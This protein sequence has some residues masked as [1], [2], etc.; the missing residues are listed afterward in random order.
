MTYRK[1]TELKDVDKCDELLKDYPDE[2]NK[3]IRS[4]E[5]ITTPK[6]RLEYAKDI[7]KFYDYTAEVFDIETKDVNIEILNKLNSDFFEDF[8]HYLRKYERNGRVYSNSDVSIKRKLSA[9]RSYFNFLFE[10][11][12]IS[13]NQILKIKPPKLRD[14]EIIRMNDDETSRFVKTV[15]QGT[16][17]SKRQVAYH[18]KQA[19]R[20]M[21][22]CYLLLSTGMRVSELVGLD[23]QDIDM[24]DCSVRIVRKG[25]REASVWFSDEAAEFLRDYIEERKKIKT[26]DPDEKAL[27]LSSRKQRISVGAVEVLVKK[28]ARVSVPQKNITVHKLRSTYG[29]KLYEKT[30]DIYL[31]ADNLGHNDI[32]TTKKHYANLSNRRKADSRNIINIAND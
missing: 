22:I 30:G 13:S 25:G 16:T 32:S 6:T 15:N 18:K 17:F 7:V 24:N 2:L 19:V 26:P 21:A 12:L 8:L 20:D 29:T 5:F 14:K 27:F 11:E 10:K 31:V 3:Y 28:Y 23:L 9:I 1:E 4:V